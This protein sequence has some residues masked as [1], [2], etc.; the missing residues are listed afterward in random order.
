MG[1]SNLDLTEARREA[2]IEAVAIDPNNVPAHVGLTRINLLEGKADDAKANI[3]AA[4]AGDP[5]NAR[6]QF[7]LGKVLE[8]PGTIDEVE[9]RGP[10]TRRR[11][12]SRPRTTSPTWRCRST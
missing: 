3:M 6:V 1:K 12:S 10:R 7:W 11:S 9:V 4:A 2:W 5:Q 8:A